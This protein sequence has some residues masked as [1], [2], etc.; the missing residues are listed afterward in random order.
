MNNFRSA[1]GLIVLACVAIGCGPKATFAALNS[2]PPRSPKPTS[3]VAFFVPGGTAPCETVVVGV[4]EVRG[5]NSIA[6]AAG[7]MRAEV[8]TR[9]LD[10][11]LDFSCAAPGTVGSEYGYCAGTAYYCK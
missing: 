9:G 11:V 3:A 6:L 7:K 2:A 1:L 8:A 5:G 4:I 10:G